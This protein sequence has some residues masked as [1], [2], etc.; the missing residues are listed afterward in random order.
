M[1]APVRGALRLQ[2]RA[3]ARPWGTERLGRV[4][5]GPVGEL[6]LAAED[7]TILDGPMAGA[8]VAEWVAGSGQRVLGAAAAALDGGRFPFL[9][10]I[11]GTG[12]WMSVQVHPDDAAAQRQAPDSDWRGKHEFWLILDAEAGARLRLGVRPSVCRSDLAGAAGTVAVSELLAMRAPHLDELHEVPPGTLHAIGPGLTIWEAQTR[13]DL[14]WRLWDFG[15]D[16]PLQIAEGLAVA[17]LAPAPEPRLLRGGRAAGGPFVIERLP[18]EAP[19]MWTAPA[20]S[21]A[22]LTRLTRPATDAA[23]LLVPAA[24]EVHLPAGDW[25]ALT[26]A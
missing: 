1:I 12:D 10:K 17:E 24:A 5:D 16:R 9:V 25:I 15:R 26:A 8:S 13:S 20:A 18:G 14:T 22:V 4:V 23:A 3:I 19:R 6:R 7:S 11:L 2:S 21:C